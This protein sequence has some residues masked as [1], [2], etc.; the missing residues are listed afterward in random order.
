[1]SKYYDGSIIPWTDPRLSPFQS[2][3]QNRWK[4]RLEDSPLNDI[5]K[6]FNV[7]HFIVSQAQPYLAPFLRTDLHQP[8]IKHRGLWKVSIVLLQQFAKEIRLRLHQANQMGWLPSWAARCLLDEHIPGLSL[9][10]VPKLEKTDFLRLLDQPVPE[11]IDYWI[12]KGERSVWPAVKALKTRCVIEIELQRAL[13]SSKRRTSPRSTAGARSVAG[14][15]GSTSH[16]AAGGSPNGVSGSGASSPTL[17]DA[18]SSAQRGEE[19][20]TQVVSDDLT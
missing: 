13:E 15:S 10:L 16:V 12:S 20:A 14:P 2:S 1:M 11:A 19:E 17:V 3:R 6:Q 7:N 5:R 4:T 8:N 9:T 18:Q